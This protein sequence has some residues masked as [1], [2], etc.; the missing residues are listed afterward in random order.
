MQGCRSK[1]PVQLIKLGSTLHLFGSQ[2]GQVGPGPE[3]ACTD[4]CGGH[5][6]PGG[7][8][9]HIVTVG[10]G[11]GIHC[12]HSLGLGCGQEADGADNRRQDCLRAHSSHGHIAAGYCCSSLYG[13]TFLP[14]LESFGQRNHRVSNPDMIHVDV[15]VANLGQ[16]VNWQPRSMQGT[17]LPLK[18]NDGTARA[19]RHQFHFWGAGLR[20]GYACL[21]AF[22]ADTATRKKSAS[23]AVTDNCVWRSLCA[24]HYVLQKLSCWV[25]SYSFVG[26][27]SDRQANRPDGSLAGRGLAATCWC[28]KGDQA[29]P[30]ST[31]PPDF[32]FHILKVKFTMCRI[33]VK[34]R[35]CSACL[36][37]Y[38]CPAAQARKYPLYVR[39]GQAHPAFT[40][41]P[42]H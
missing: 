39:L 40:S 41:T 42:S 11:C 9:L 4:N 35:L 27:S 21:H 14:A 30:S 3:S 34:L 2:D 25:S 7:I 5:C 32:G 38:I 10:E 16:A 26:P 22:V 29:L 8:H 23:A 19:T 18:G 17:V 28:T 13:S 31:N 36:E 1:T 33:T 37:G 6:N 15:Y 24:L 20:T 12:H